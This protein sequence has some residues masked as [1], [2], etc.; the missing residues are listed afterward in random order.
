MQPGLGCPFFFSIWINLVNFKCG[1]VCG[2]EWSVF[3][4]LLLT[5][6]SHVEITSDF[7]Q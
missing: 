4:C 2:H 7:C 3:V 5:Q 6:P 1:C